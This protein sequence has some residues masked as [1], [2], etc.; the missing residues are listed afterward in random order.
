MPLKNGGPQRAGVVAL[1]PLDLD[2]VGAHV[3][4][5]LGHHRAGQVLRDLDDADAF[6]RQHQRNSERAMTMR[7]TSEGPSPM[8]RTR[9]SRYQRSSGNSFDT[10]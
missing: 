9:A 5:D 4:E 1:G 7:C 6:Q 2:D 10:P 3:G 8:R